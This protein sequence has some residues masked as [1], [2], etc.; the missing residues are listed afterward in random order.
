M[1]L[2]SRPGFRTLLGFRLTAGTL[3]VPAQ[4]RQEPVEMAG[5]TRAGMALV[6]RE[7]RSRTDGWTIGI[8]LA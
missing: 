1:S 6:F 8:C 7:F 2:R 3:H 5:V 4:D